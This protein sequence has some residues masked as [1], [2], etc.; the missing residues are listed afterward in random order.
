[1]PGERE[2]GSLAQPH[3]SPSPTPPSLNP[4]LPPPLSHSFAF[5]SLLSTEIAK[6]TF[7][8]PLKVFIYKFQNHTTLDAT[9]LYS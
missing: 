6:Q 9:L 4:S 7:A 3:P 8:N 1:M 5:S 2:G